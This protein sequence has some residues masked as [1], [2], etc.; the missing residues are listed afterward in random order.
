M[1]IIKNNI[2][3]PGD[4]EAINLFGFVFARR[5]LTPRDRNHEAI[6]SA[7]MREMGYLP[8]YLWYVLEWL[9]RLPFAGK[10]AY[11]NISFEQEAYGNEGDLDYLKTRKHF[12]WL[13]YFKK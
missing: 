8:F 12:A 10:E 4:F 3:P 7:Q 9:I 13:K 6:H 5:E 2:F 11:F 1:K